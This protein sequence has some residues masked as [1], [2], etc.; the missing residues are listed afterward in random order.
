MHK[1]AVF[2]EC[3]IHVEFSTWRCGGIWPKVMV[4]DFFFFLQ[5]AYFLFWFSYFCSVSM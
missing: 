5:F 2:G 4:L 3:S 1:G